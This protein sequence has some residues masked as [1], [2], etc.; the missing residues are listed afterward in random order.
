MK[1]AV[2]FLICLVMLLTGVA[3]AAEEAVSQAELQSAFTSKINEFFAGMGPGKTLSFHVSPEGSQPLTGALSVIADE[4]GQELDDLTILLPGQEKPVQVQFSKAEQTIYAKYQ[5]RV[6][7]L[8]IS[9]LQEMLQSLTSM[10]SMP[11][12]DPQIT[13]E[14]SLLFMTNVIMPGI[15][16]ENNQGVITLRVDLKAKDV[17]AGLVRF[18]DQ[19]MATEK[20]WDAVKPLLRF[21]GMRLMSNPT[22]L[23]LMYSGDGEATQTVDFVEAFE[24]NWPKLKEQLLALETD[25][26]L[27]A[28]AIIRTVA[29]SGTTAVVAK[30]T[31]SQDGQSVIATL[32]AADNQKR[33][34]LG[35]TLATQ[36]G[37]VAEPVT[38]ATLDVKCDKLAGNLNAVLTLPNDHIDVKLTG[39]LTRRGDA[40]AIQGHLNVSRSGAPVAVADADIFSVNGAV[41]ANVQ[42]TANGTTVTGGLYWSKFVKTL[43]VNAQGQTLKAEIRSD[44]EGN[45]SAELTLPGNQG[46]FLA[47]GHAT[48]SSLHCTVT[49]SDQRSLM[50]GGAPAFSAEVTAAW[51]SL[52]LSTNVTVISGGKIYAGQAYFGRSAQK[53]S[54]QGGETTLV[55]DFQEDSRNQLTLGRLTYAGANSSNRGFEITYTPDALVYEDAQLKIT[56]TDS[57]ASE[58]EYVIDAEV[59][60]KS[61]E[62]AYNAYADGEGSLDDQQADSAVS[63]A[64]LRI[65]LIE[66]ENRIEVTVENVRT[67]LTA[68]V[69]IQPAG[70]I[71]QLSQQEP[72]YIT[73]ELLQQLATDPSALE[74]LLQ[75]VP[76][77]EEQ[78]ESAPAETVE[79]PVVEEHAVE[80]PVDAVEEPAAGSSFLQRLVEGK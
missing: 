74:K 38:Q 30:I 65:R 29:E 15:K 14:L 55:L 23:P 60:N 75:P 68:G 77:E 56:V 69:A 48:D 21:V 42:V 34:E 57:Y 66:E 72:V 50:R 1:K 67:A 40:L 43:T 41:T 3:A 28:D 12:M 13:Q 16:T 47:E 45:F 36:L 80:A 22:V 18:V 79:A 53:I 44:E 51:S 17:V 10:F 11:K 24:K 61:R 7:A 70:E 9:D 19:V 27:T 4:E 6:F 76:A 5:D 39:S 35:L 20:Y 33:F 25:A 37:G 8:R 62:D 49:Y 73:A 32:S 54:Y 52:G 71:A 78:A 31:Y 58:T 46:K 63:H 64:Y 59:V 26:R 2:S